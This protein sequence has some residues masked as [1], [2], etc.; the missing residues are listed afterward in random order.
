MKIF[1]PSGKDGEKILLRHPLLFTFEAF[2]FASS[3]TSEKKY[4]LSMVVYTH[5]FESEKTHG[6]Y[7]NEEE[8]MKTRKSFCFAF[9]FF[10]EARLI[11]AVICDVRNIVE[12]IEKMKIFI[13]R[14]CEK[15]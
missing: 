15:K 5:K 7:G 11:F 4:E 3:T 6:V 14:E 1:T 9:L 8:K 10:V 12:T 13:S 2:A